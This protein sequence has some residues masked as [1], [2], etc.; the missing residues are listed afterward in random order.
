MSTFTDVPAF[1][2]GSGPGRPDSGWDVAAP[3]PTPSN[4]VPPVTAADTPPGKRACAEQHSPTARIVRGPGGR[5]L[6]ADRPV[7]THAHLPAPRISGYPGAL[8]DQLT[9]YK[10]AVDIFRPLLAEVGDAQ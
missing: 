7:L 6:T 2:L 10:R 3:R 5:S 1:L 8:V 4:D 9:Q